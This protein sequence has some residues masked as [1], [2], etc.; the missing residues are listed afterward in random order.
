VH[1]PIHDDP[2]LPFNSGSNLVAE[3]EH[4]TELRYTQTLTSGTVRLRATTSIAL[5]NG[6]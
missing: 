2:A 5:K 4:V 3:T 6:A 1:A